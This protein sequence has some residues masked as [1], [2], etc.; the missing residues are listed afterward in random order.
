MNVG[1]EFRP[2]ICPRCLLGQ[3]KNFHRTFS[4]GR[5][6][7]QA[8]TPQ[9]EQLASEDTGV[10]ESPIQESQRAHGAGR[11]SERLAQMTEESIDGGGRSAKKVIKEGGFPEE[12]KRQLE[13]RIKDSTFRSDNPAA[14]AQANMPVSK[15]LVHF[16]RTFILTVTRPAQEKG[17]A[18]SQLVNP[19]Q[20]LRPLKMPR[21]EC[22]MMPISPFVALGIL[23][24]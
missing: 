13:A 3:S 15:T 1:K 6:L 10:S 14:F 11:M 9:N 19:G 22:S 17:H 21:Y 24:F 23:K 7:S 2:F 12:L 20:V 4:N 5:Y 16:S 8:P 18:M